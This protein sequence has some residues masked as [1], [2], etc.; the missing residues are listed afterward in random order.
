MSRFFIDRPIF[1]VVIAL[2]IMLLGGISIL[3]LP[4]EQYP[5]IAPPTVTISANYPG[6]SAETVENTVTQVIERELTG[7]DGLLYFSA[8]S[9]SD[10][11]CSIELTF[12]QG[13]DPDIAQ[14]QTQNKVQQISSRLPA[15]VQQQGITVKKSQGNILMMVVLYDTNGTA[16]NA[17]VADYLVSNV[18]D[19]LARIDGVGNIRLFGDQYAMRIWMEPMKLRS[20]NLM[21][22]DIRTALEQQN[23]QASMGKLGDLPAAKGQNLT[24]TVTAASMLQTPTEF[25]DIIVKY[26]SDGSVVR[27]GDVARVEM[28]SESYNTANSMNKLPS[29]ALSVQLA[30]GAN[31]LNTSEQVR[32]LMA[33]MEPNLPDGYAVEY[34]N[35][36][37]EFVKLSIR[38][39]VQTLIEA[40]VLV[41]VIMYFFLG[42]WR[43]TVIPAVTVPVVLLGT[44]AAMK[45]LG[46][47]INTLT[48]FGL[49]LSIGLLIDDTIVVVENV[50]RLMREKGLAAREAT[51][52]SMREIT[53][54]LVGI[55]AIMIVVFMPMIFFSGS[56]GI[57]Y[58]QFSVTIIAS[59]GLSV[60]M[61]LTLAPAMCAFLLKQHSGKIGRFQ[62]F[63]D[64][65]LAG[66]EKQVGKTL[67]RPVRWLAAYVLISG[68]ALL[69][70]TQLSTGFLPNED[71]GILICQYQLPPGAD[72]SRTSE[73][74]KLI[75]TYF[76]EEEKDNVSSILTTDGFG[77]SSSGQHNG[78]AFI[79]LRNWSE[80]QGAYNSSDG[81]ATRAMM[82]LSSIR[83]AQIFVFNLPPIMGLGQTDGL[84]LYLQA[85]AGTDRAELES[86]LTTF[87]EKS[88]QE[89][90]LGNMRS[91]NA[92]VVPQLHLVF[93]TEKALSYGI[94]IDDMYDTLNAAW[95][96][97]YVN[98]FID[99]NRV[100][101]V[102]LQAEAESRSKPEDL[103]TWSVRNAAGQM[104][105]YSE[106]T[107]P[108][109]VSSP[110]TLERFNGTP[111]YYVQGSAATGYSSGDAMQAVQNVVAELPGTDFA[112]SGLS[113]Q[114][115]Q[116]SGQ[117][118]ML[119]CASI[120]VIFLCLAAL[121]ESWSI[122]IA[123][124][125]VI[126][127][128]VLGAVL[129]AH[130]RGLENNIYFQ[131]ALLT[132]IG[133]SARNAIMMVEFADQAHK[134]G[135][136]LAEA[137]V[138]AAV[139]RLRPIVMTALTFGAG[140][141]P[142]A[143]SSGVGANSR[144]AIGTGT[145]G[146]TISATFL[147]I[148]FIPLFFLLVSRLFAKKR[149]GSVKHDV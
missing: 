122:P 10:G 127:L 6:A 23:R 74:S 60:L 41:I 117:T 79:T 47:T 103:Q 126:P 97:E 128:G 140:V 116:A 22:S 139:L 145:L 129:G 81:I 85:T 48:L 70:L 68:G 40:V 37:S 120:L 87:L 33:E 42:N 7:L 14:V 63:F 39:V 5:D 19:R 80:R 61:A 94:S 144:I 25:R 62:R 130:M 73:V 32:A 111:A 26:K 121:Y 67:S 16:S 28:G 76:L 86:R 77:L 64:R 35:D 106:F 21:P 91:D 49:V 11:D 8:T 72:M 113:Y 93:N 149:T 123:V 105:P 131:V 66:Y 119:Y 141:L 44:F 3:S 133:L 107:Q 83:D 13:T 78:M 89:K 57:I 1:A 125:L 38:E 135:M 56:T 45:V 104:V 65:A 82:K 12:E 124:L 114:E 138:H 98:D 59:M 134:L 136:G 54:A 92:Y 101:K 30:S 132:I 147:T 146:G 4:M 84:E 90:A 58:R 34:A 142:L 36:N 52:E 137:A 29:A 102:Y 27:L 31:A 118:V 108:S 88:G 17:D 109:W 99:R 100:K 51:V 143:L 115:Q 53:G 71:Q 18:Q 20:Y 46:F 110:E 148:F 50:E 2:L 112:W 15:V 24:A 43:A 96:G 95:A 75:S 55:T 9:K 69:L